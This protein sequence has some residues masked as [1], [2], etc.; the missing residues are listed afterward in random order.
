LFH[1]ALQP[2]PKK[3]PHL[4]K[5]FRSSKSFATL[6]QDTRAESKSQSQF[7]QVV[8]VAKDVDRHVSPFSCFVEKAASLTPIEKEEIKEEIETRVWVWGNDSHG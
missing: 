5:Q 8:K 6:T 1:Q 3:P 7:P 2:K 4:N